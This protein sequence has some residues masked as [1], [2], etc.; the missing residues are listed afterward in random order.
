M[1]QYFRFR[2]VQS[3]FMNCSY[4]H[5]HID[6]HGAVDFSSDPLRVDEK[7][8]PSFFIDGKY[9][10]FGRF[11]R[12]SECFTPGGFYCVLSCDNFELSQEFKR[13]NRKAKK[14]AIRVDRKRRRDRGELVEP[15]SK[16]S[17]AFRSLTKAIRTNKV[18]TFLSRF[19]FLSFDFV[20]FSVHLSPH[21]L[22][23]FF[24]HHLHHCVPFV[25][26]LLLSRFCSCSVVFTLL[27]PP[28]SFLSL[29]DLS[30][31]HSSSLFYSSFNSSFIIFVVLH[32]LVVVLFCPVLPLLIYLSVFRSLFSFST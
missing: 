18:R 7:E 9:I 4:G 24:S 2:D 3:I 30:I 19:S 17:A 20:T 5:C 1:I 14:F 10:R 28:F 8:W 12:N 13:Q 22:N 6:Y 16:R 26:L 11:C 31:L 15:R 27:Q 29:H 21:F 23:D 32:S 25:S